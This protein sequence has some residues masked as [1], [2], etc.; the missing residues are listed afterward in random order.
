VSTPSNLWQAPT[1]AIGRDAATWPVLARLPEIEEPTKSRPPA[2]D[3][4]RATRS[5]DYRFDPPQ[6][7]P[8]HVAGWREDERKSTPFSSPIL[9]S[10]DPFAIPASS[11][12][13]A[14]APVIRFLILTA[15]FTMAGTMVL[16]IGKEK[17]GDAKRSEP[18][19][20]TVGQS[21]QPTDIVVPT[22][23]AT[24]QAAAPPAAA[25]PTASSS[26]LS[27]QSEAIAWPEDDLN[28]SM[29]R[30]DDEP[31]GRH[32]SIEDTNSAPWPNEPSADLR[33]TA[34]QQLQTASLPKVQI[35]EPPISVAHLPG[36]LESPPAG[37]SHDD[38]KSSV[39]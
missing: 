8:Y 9:P 3:R 15:L 2:A 5:T 4:T 38:N 25:G 28:S 1:T 35:A 13:E 12:H 34:S 7:R 16:M 30:D 23:V 29:K 26:A 31:Q 19:T 14:I 6:P 20:A 11:L 24:E 36:H 18:V 32:A 21:L 33:A 10:S 17:R 27:G 22:P 39:H 37:A